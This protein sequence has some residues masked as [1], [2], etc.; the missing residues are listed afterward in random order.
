MAI[1]YI[2]LPESL[3]GKYQYYT[4]AS[5]EKL[6]EAGY[7]RPTVP[8]EEGLGMYFEEYLLREDIFR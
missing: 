5:L 3:R 4:L 2:D 1:E 7:P 8:L 6:R